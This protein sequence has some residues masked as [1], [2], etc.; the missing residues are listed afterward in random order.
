[1]VTLVK[2]KKQLQSFHQP[3][4]LKPVRKYN[5]EKEKDLGILPRSGC[6]IVRDIHKTH[7]IQTNVGVAPYDLV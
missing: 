4:D 3:A 7:G 2:M 1:M 5:N 6:R